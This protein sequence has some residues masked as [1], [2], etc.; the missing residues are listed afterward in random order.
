M[1]PLLLLLAAVFTLSAQSPD[2]YAI[3]RR[4]VELDLETPQFPSDFAF[5]KRIGARIAFENAAGLPAIYNAAI[6]AQDARDMFVKRRRRVRILSKHLNGFGRN[7]S[8][9]S[10]SR[11]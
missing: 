5:D 3:V 9:F 7:S 8:S 1:R 11:L 10:Q 4:A 2:P 6:A